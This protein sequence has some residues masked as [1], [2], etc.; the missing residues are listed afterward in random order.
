LFFVRALLRFRSR[1]VGGGI[2]DG[3]G[4]VVGA[5]VGELLAPGDCVWGLSSRDKKRKGRKKKEKREGKDARIG[6][7]VD[8]VLTVADLFFLSNLG[9]VAMD[10]LGRSQT[11]VRSGASSIVSRE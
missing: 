3:I 4:R 7:F 1:V 8:A 9:V 5:T 6:G 10:I 2:G 11:I